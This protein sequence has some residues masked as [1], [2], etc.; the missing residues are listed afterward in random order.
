MHTDTH[1]RKETHT[2][3]DSCCF[4]LLEL[5]T[6]IHC[7]PRSAWVPR[8]KAICHKVIYHKCTLTLQQCRFCS[9]PE[10]D[11]ISNILN[12]LLLHSPWWSGGVFLGVFFGWG[13]GGKYHGC[14]FTVLNHLTIV[15]P[16]IPPSP[17]ITAQTQHA[18][19]NDSTSCKKSFFYT[20]CLP[21]H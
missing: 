4:A 13:A 5:R 7:V 21:L 10:S 15:T 6:F 9:D 16:Y 14:T 17:P 20:S 8:I 11:T 18:Q 2:G 3:V 1:T 12:L 19:I